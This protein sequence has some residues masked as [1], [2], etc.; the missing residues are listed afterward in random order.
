MTGARKERNRGKIVAAFVMGT[1][2]LYAFVHDNTGQVVADSIRHTLYSG[3]GGQMDF[4]RG[5]ALA[6]EGRS[7]I[8]IAHP[9]FCPDLV[10]QARRLHT[11]SSIEFNSGFGGRPE[12]D[13]AIRQAVILQ[14]HDEEIVEG[15]D[16]PARAVVRSQEAAPVREDDPR[17]GHSG[18]VASCGDQPPVGEACQGGLR[19]HRRHVVP[20]CAELLGDP[21]AVLLVEEQLHARRAVCWRYNR[22]S[23]SAITS[24][25]S[26]QRSI[27]SANSAWY[28]AAASTIVN[29]TWR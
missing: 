6:P 15:L 19:D 16:K 2:R 12:P 4:I 20:S 26:I 28:R 27:S 25:A 10:A 21:W 22:S 29:G 18:T 8:A 23:R 9:D 13:D 1:P 14:V 5:A 17:V 11:L 3:V 7:I 24:F